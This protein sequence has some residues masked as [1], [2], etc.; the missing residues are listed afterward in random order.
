MSKIWLALLDKRNSNI[1]YLV[2]GASIMIVTFIFNFLNKSIIIGYEISI[3][4]ILY[5][6]IQTLVSY[7]ELRIRSKE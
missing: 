6:L 7:V 4:L 2:M 5:G 3:F 1:D